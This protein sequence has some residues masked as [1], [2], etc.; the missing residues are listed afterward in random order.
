MNAEIFFKKKSRALL[1]SNIFLD[2]KI[3]AEIKISPG[4]NARLKNTQLIK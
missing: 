1:K 4:N 2:V 3:H